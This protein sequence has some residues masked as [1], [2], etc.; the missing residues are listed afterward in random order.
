M[1]QECDRH[2]VRF[3]VMVIPAGAQVH[4]HEEV[5]RGLHERLG[6]DHLEYADRRIQGLAEQGGFPAILLSEPLR[7]YAVEHG[8]YLHGFRNT[9]LGEGHWNEHGHRE[10]ARVC[11]EELMRSR[12]EP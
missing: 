6:V 9:A 12:G 4:P 3:G 5:R 2:N 8:A 1:H 11:A 7:N 10:A